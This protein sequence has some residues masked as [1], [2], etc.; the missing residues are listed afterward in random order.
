MVNNKE[1]DELT[2]KYVPI[3]DNAETLAGELLRAANQI[4]YR[5]YN[6]GD[7]TDVGYG[8]E[9]VNP[10]VRFLK[11]EGTPA[12]KLIASSLFDYTISNEKYE[13]KLQKLADIVTKEIIKNNLQDVKNTKDMWDYV[14]SKLDKD[15]EDDWEED[16]EEEEDWDESLFAKLNKNISNYINEDNHY[17]ILSKEEEDNQGKTIFNS[18]EIRNMFIGT[19]LEL[20][21]D[22]MKA[23]EKALNKMPDEWINEFIKTLN[24]YQIQ[25]VDK[26]LQKI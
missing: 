23:I 10:A 12:I 7:I 1:F 3:S 2:D 22:P 19:L 16:D 8:K 13:H 5:Y 25:K 11:A 24:D 26:K 18:K 15:V 21:A 17:I 14:D 9:T 6:D 4:I 20:D